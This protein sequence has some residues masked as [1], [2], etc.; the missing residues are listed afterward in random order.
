[1]EARIYLD[2]KKIETEY[3]IQGIQIGSGTIGLLSLPVIDNNNHSS[4]ETYWVMGEVSYN[5]SEEKPQLD[6]IK[7]E[8][9]ELI[10]KVIQK[11]DIL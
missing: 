8:E 7:S 11:L 9:T 1:M 3:S 6:L 5:E 10:T 2:G 4:W